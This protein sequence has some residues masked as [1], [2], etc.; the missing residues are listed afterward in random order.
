MSELTH[1]VEALLFVASEPLSVRELATLT[2]AAPERVERALDALGD[3]YGEGRSGVVLEKAGGGWGFRAS[4]E[5]AP[6]CARL[7]NR[8]QTRGMSQ[9]GLET[10]A[11]IAYLGPVSRPDIARVRGVSADAGVA[12]L[13]ER[14]LVE[15]AGRAD[16]IGQPVLYRVTTAFARMFG[17]ED[18]TASLPSLSEFDLTDADHE[19]LRARLHLVADQRAGAA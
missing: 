7:L 13:L 9:A 3:R 16:T 11:I 6:A 10:L 8:P 1:T 19:A 15:E 12:G 5:T 18:G 2:E 17:L 14:G 4:R